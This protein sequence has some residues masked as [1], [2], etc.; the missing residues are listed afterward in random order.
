MQTDTLNFGNMV[1]CDFCCI[2]YTD[3]TVSGGIIFH[4]KAACPDCS[5]HI[6]E[7]C[8]KYDEEHFIEAQCP[9]DKSFADFVRDFRGGNAI[10]T[11][12]SF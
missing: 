11:I 8:R 3:S 6:L 7:D 12:T 10:I 1:I 5:S 9:E 4:H 2:D